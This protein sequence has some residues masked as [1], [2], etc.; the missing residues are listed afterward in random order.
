M[1]V[2]TIKHKGW[3]IEVQHDQFADNP[4]NDGNFEIMP[5]D[6]YTDSNDEPLELVGELI[7]QG[8][9]WPIDYF[10]HGAQCKYSLTDDVDHNWGWIVFTDEYASNF[11]RVDDRRE[12]AR[13]DLEEYTAWANGECYGITVAD[14]YGDEEPDFACWGIIGDYGWAVDEAKRLIEHTGINYAT[15]AKYAGELHR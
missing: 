4:V 6:S 9:M 10:E 14:P 12:M 13:Q 15:K 2:D 7:E 11:T 5:R 3:T 8:K 1:T